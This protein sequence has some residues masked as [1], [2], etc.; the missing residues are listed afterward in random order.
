MKALFV[1]FAPSL[2]HV[3]R[4]LAVAEAWRALGHEAVFAI[5]SE[6][7][8][9]V[10]DAAFATRPVPEVPGAVFCTDRGFRWLSARYLAENLQAEQAILFGLKPDLVVF[11]F[12]FTAASS[13]RLAGLPSVGILHGNAIRLA[14]QPGR[15]AELLIDEP[16]MALKMS[17]GIQRLVRR[18]FP[19]GFRAVLRMV[20]WRL[21]SVLS[22]H[23]LPRVDSP[24][25]LLLGEESLIAD[26]PALLP[27]ELPPRAHIVGPLM[28]SGWGGPAPWLDTLDAKPL[29]YV[30]MGST[31]TNRSLLARILDALH[32]PAYNV[33]VSTGSLSLPPER[34]W[35]THIRSF[36]TV[37]G[38]TIA[39]HSALVVHHGGHET[40]MQALAAGVASLM[41]P[42]NPDQIL[43]AQQA[44]ALGLGRSL[45]QPGGLPLGNQPLNKVTSSQIRREIDDLV[46][47]PECAEAC[48]AVRQ[49]MATYRGPA[50][51]AEMLQR[52]ARASSG[53]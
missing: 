22:A 14:Q 11:D 2:A 35:P 26:I 41:A 34:Q 50:R 37:P 30:T 40:L 10:Q 43:V 6:R 12:R 44:Q 9:M 31:V 1:P 20:A 52:I 38:S 36:A 25:E 39:R 23:G 24:F 3:S 13:A 18:L 47:D 42:A 49:E 45:R 7:S 33:V 28:W 53:T 21:S 19:L 5:G 29:I 32:D 15:T 48:Q 8:A 46:A 4:C 51:A 17:A 27:T 16:A